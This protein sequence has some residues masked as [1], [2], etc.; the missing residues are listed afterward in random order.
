[1]PL[2]LYLQMAAR[3]AR[4]WLIGGALWVSSPISVLAQG[5]TSGAAALPIPARFK[6]AAPKA[7]PETRMAAPAAENA[8]WW[9]IFHDRALEALEAEAL[10][11]NQDLR[12]AVARVVEARQQMRI[13][14]ADFYPHLEAPLRADRQRTTNTGPV[15]RGR[16]VGDFASALPATPAGAGAAASPLN[17][18]S[19]FFNRPVATQPL[20]STF[21]D[22]RAP[23]TLTYEVDVFGRIRAAYGQAH[24]NAQAA[25]EDRRAVELSLT[26]Q[27]AASYFNLRALDAE[28]AILRR[29]V[30]VRWEAVR[31]QKERAGLGA[32]TN[33]EIARAEVELANAESDLTDVNR[34]RGEAENGLAA[35][36]GVFASSFRMAPHA[37]GDEAPP[38]IPAGIP[39]ALLG[40]RPD[41]VEAE[42]KI[43]AAAQGI[44]IAR[45]E[46]LPT[47][48]LEGDGGYETANSNQLLEWQSRTWQLLATVKVPIFEGGRNVANLEEAKARR[49]E[50]LG[51]YHQA[52]LVAFR[53]VE[54]ALVDLRER[55]AQAEARGRAA[56][57]SQ[58]VLELS[59]QRYFEGAITYLDVV[60]AQR[61]LLGSEL[62]RVETLAAR[63]SATIE[64]I[65]ALGGRYDGAASRTGGKS[66]VPV[67][68]R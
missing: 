37:L 33:L 64:L 50:A 26:A 44:R 51:A 57:K 22:F 1:M 48:D 54:N 23:L 18:L 27:V 29:T 41:L 39:A 11:A 5:G 10:A 62:S 67:S 15:Q 63:Y 46:L 17:T 16:F 43:A 28:A 56:A 9:E 42:R 21:D 68:S 32:G 66:P 40:Q 13:A 2:I 60:D 55:A 34:Q 6:G 31:L 24:A 47:F 3:V 53:E 7:R 12:Q 52:A 25:Q 14:A 20:S 36:C 30:R 38:Q 4:P 49:A 65:R 59:Q 8:G 61:L 58:E 19:Q 45:A 35:L